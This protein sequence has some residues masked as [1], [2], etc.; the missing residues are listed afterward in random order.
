MMPTACLS[1]RQLTVSLAILLGLTLPS[2]GSDDSGLHAYEGFDYPTGQL[3]DRD[4][5][6]GWDGPW[7]DAHQRVVADESLA[8]ELGETPQT[9]GGHAL[10]TNGDWPAKR[11]LAKPFAVEPGVYWVSVIAANVDGGK[12]ETYAR[13]G[14]ETATDKGGMGLVKAHNAPNWGIEAGGRTV[15]SRVPADERAV[16]LVARLTVSDEPEG[17]SVALFI[18]PDLGREPVTPD[19]EVSRVTLLPMQ[20]LMLR[21]GVGKKVFAFDEVRLGRTFESVLP[22]P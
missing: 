11:K 13:M 14:L 9:S 17:S 7:R 6:V 4:G 19:A 22:Q 16:L 12:E 8:S 1:L 5:G 15:H 20:T 21:S 18:D 3:R 2:F 10:L